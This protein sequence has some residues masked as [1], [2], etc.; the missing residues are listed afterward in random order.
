MQKIIKLEKIKILKVNKIKL[1]IILLLL[2][3]LIINF[4]SKLI[5]IYA[6]AFMKNLGFSLTEI[7]ITGIK[8]LDESEI[9]KHIQYRNCSNLFCVNLT[10]T[11]NSLEKLDLV[12][13]ANI[14]IVLPSKLNIKILEEKPKFL[15]ENGNDFFVLNSEGKRIS[16]IRKNIDLYNDL[17]VVGGENV[18]EKV[19]DLKFIL[20]ESPDL[21]KKITSAKLISN[22]R[23]S[24]VLSYFTTLD[25]PEKNPNTALKKLDFLNKKYGLLSDNIKKID[26]RVENRMIIK[27]NINDFRFKENKV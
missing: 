24:L 6:D 23:W 22:R 21:A 16:K 10:S 26:L 9:K 11:K 25:L 7:K 4:Q 19:K 12:K 1:G 3:L 2:F 20:A 14:K 13:N 18:L 8:S 15:F 27:F 17:I 5:T